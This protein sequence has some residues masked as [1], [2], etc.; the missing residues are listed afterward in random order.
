MWADDHGRCDDVD[1][2][3]DVLRL[4]LISWTD[5]NGLTHVGQRGLR[6]QRDYMLLCRTPQ[7]WL[8]PNPLATRES[9]LAA[10]VRQEQKTPT[11][12]RCAFVFEGYV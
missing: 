5:P 6:N 1:E 7:L 12:L 3:Y 9:F 8:G 10:V 4:H 11:C 2:T